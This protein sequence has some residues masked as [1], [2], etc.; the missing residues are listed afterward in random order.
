MTTA[1]SSVHAGLADHFQPF[2]TGYRYQF[3]TGKRVRHEYE[4]GWKTRWNVTHI[5]PGVGSDTICVEIPQDSF[6]GAGGGKV[7]KEAWV[8][9]MHQTFVSIFFSRK[10]VLVVGSV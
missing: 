9:P 7:G 1:S 5:E 10:S 8:L 2:S 3:K 6:K 4:R